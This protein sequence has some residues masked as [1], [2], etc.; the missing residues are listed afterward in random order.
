MILGQSSPSGQ[1]HIEPLTQLA[2]Q[3]PPIHIHATLQG[4]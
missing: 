3:P 4:I 2:G 1:T